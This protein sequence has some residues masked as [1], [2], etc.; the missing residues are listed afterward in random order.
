MEIVA[1]QFQFGSGFQS[2]KSNALSLSQITG[3]T[4]LHDNQSA[5]QLLLND[6][7][8]WP[9]EAQ[10]S[11]DQNR[12]SQDFQ[13][14]IYKN[15]GGFVNTETASL[16]IEQQQLYIVFKNKDGEITNTIPPTKHDSQSIDSDL[17][18]NTENK[19]D[20]YV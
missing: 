2:L 6:D 5:T 4:K 17:L 3:Q 10:K 7:L 20:L 18:F 9:P 16:T 14:N 15:D 12:E 11:S 8:S 19:V 13:L 1:Q